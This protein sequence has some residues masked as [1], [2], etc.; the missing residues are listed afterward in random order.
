MWRFSLWSRVHT[1]GKWCSTGHVVVCGQ[2]RFVM[3]TSAICDERSGRRLRTVTFCATVMLA[4]PCS[5]CFG[6]IWKKTA[7]GSASVIATL[8]SNWDQMI[9]VL[10]HLLLW[11]VSD[12]QKSAQTQKSGLNLKMAAIKQVSFWRWF[13]VMLLCCV[14][15]YLKLR[16]K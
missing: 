13:Y 7:G 6:N 15:C 9:S 14:C 5:E 16:K 1:A 2:I 11:F 3:C 12:L 10:N 4:S 8:I